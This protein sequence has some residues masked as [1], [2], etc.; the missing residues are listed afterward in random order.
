MDQ[1]MRILSPAL[2]LFTAL[3]HVSAQ[4]TR[5]VAEPKIPS[6]CTV[7]TAQLA[8][9]GTALPNFD[10]SKPDTSRIQQAMD[11]CKAGQAVELKASATR[12][13]FLTGPIELRSNVTLLIDKGVILYGSRNPRDYDVVPGLCGTITEKKYAYTQGV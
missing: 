10:E 5:T 11:H 6:S 13:A 8:S 1:N 7:L 12:D 3:L 9:H 4:D 2:L